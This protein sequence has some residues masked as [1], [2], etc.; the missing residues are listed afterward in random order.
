MQDGQIVSVRNGFVHNYRRSG[1]RDVKLCITLEN[2]ICEIQLHISSFYSLK[3]YQHVVYEWSRG[4]NV[5]VE[6][7][8][9]NLFQ[10]LGPGTLAQMIDLAQ[11]NWQSTGDALYFLRRAAGEYGESERL[12]RQVRA[13]VRWEYCD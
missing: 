10:K 2:H 7:K 13:R 8:A 12:L 4:L 9:E 6:I 5:A 11:D 1:Y 3:D